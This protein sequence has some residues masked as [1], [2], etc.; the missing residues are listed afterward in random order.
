[1]SF[2]RHPNRCQVASPV[3]PSQRLGI[4]P[5]RLYPVTALLGDERR[6]NDITLDSH[7]GQ[8]SM[9][10]K[11]TRAVL[12]A[13]IQVPANPKFHHQLPHCLRCVANSGHITDSPARPSSATATEIDD[14]CTSIPT[15][16]VFFMSRPL[17]Y[18][19]LCYGWRFTIQHNLRTC[20]S[21]RLH[22]PNYNDVTLTFVRA[23]MDLGDRGWG[24]RGRYGRSVKRRVG[25]DGV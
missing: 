16:R 17:S 15:N 13:A 4:S 12:V 14:T 3:Q 10:D 11:A 1:M 24:S 9:Q 23:L 22:H 19:A 25:L 21:G 5:V 7:V 20:E 6:G 18:V 2:V 8:L